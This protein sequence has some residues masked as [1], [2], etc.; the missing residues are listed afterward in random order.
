MT[1]TAQSNPFTR[2]RNRIRTRSTPSSGVAPSCL[3]SL[4]PAGAGCGSSPATRTSRRVWAIR[5]WATPGPRRRGFPKRSRSKRAAPA[6]DLVSR[7]ALAE[8]PGDALSEVELLAMVSLLIVAGHETTVNLI[9]NGML[10][11]LRHPDQLRALAA[12]PNLNGC[13]I[14]ELLRYDSPVETTMI[15]QA[16]A[17]LELGGSTIR[18]GGQV[19]LV[20][21]AANRDESRRYIETRLS[22]AW[23]LVAAAANRDSFPSAEQLDITRSANRHLS[24]GGAIHYC[25]GAQLAR[26][27]GRI[28]IGA[29][30]RR[31]LDLRLAVPVEQLEWR[32]QLLF[33]GLR[34]LPVQ[35]AP[36]HFHW[37]SRDEVRASEI[38]ADDAVLEFPQSGERIRGRAAG[39]TF[40][41]QR[42]TGR[43]DLWVDEYTIRYDG[44][45]PHMVAGIMEFHDGKVFRGRPYI[46]EPWDPPAW[47][48]QRVEPIK[49][50]EL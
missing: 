23:T 28:A 40:E 11:L 47:R 35:L 8:E 43:D 32:S 4:S 31:R 19:A 44:E 42:T 30:L 38:Y 50:G 46:N 13:A 36:H 3:H 20:V 15:R 49:A 24:F 21:A 26:A 18:A 12:D 2:W 45:R 22:A 6:D 48:A 37:A 39:V 29:L 16:G 7:L 1:Q 25:I 10:A 33:R 5:A 17:D 27:Q 9:G 34:S 41:M 14:E